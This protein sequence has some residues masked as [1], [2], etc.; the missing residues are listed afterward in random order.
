MKANILIMILLCSGTT[1]ADDI[2]FM[3]AMQPYTKGLSFIRCSDSEKELKKVD[4]VPAQIK[5]IQVQ[6]RTNLAISSKAIEIL[7]PSIN[8]ASDQ[9]ASGV[10]TVLNVENDTVRN[11]FMSDSILMKNKKTIV[12]T[13]LQIFELTDKQ[14][15][16][17]KSIFTL[18]ENGLVQQKYCNIVMK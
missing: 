14:T 9:L 1:F 4:F 2:N 10:K 13:R 3:E 5:M 8:L 16:N 15:L 11:Q 12:G 17:Y 18:F 7:I 6:G